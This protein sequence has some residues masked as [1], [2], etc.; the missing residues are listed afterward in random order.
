MNPT[1]FPGNISFNAQHSPMGAF[2]SFTCGHFGTRGGIG[3]Q[4]GRPAN[5]DLFVGVKNGDRYSDEPIHCLPFFEGA[6]D[7]GPKGLDEAAQAFLVEQGVARN[8]TKPGIVAIDRKDIHR[9]YRWATDAWHAH[10]FEFAIYTPFD[11]IPDPS[12]ESPA[13]ALLP[14]ITAELVVHN[15][16]SQTKTACFAIGFQDPG[17][18]LLD[19]GV[20]RGR[21][22]F[23]LRNQIGVLAALENDEAPHP[24]PFM[25]WSAHE[26]L[27]DHTPVHL[28]GNTPGIGFEIPPGESRSLRIA[29]GCYLDGVVT[30]RIE[31]KYFYTRHYA[32][33]TDVLRFALDR[34]TEFEDRAANL[35]LELLQS[36][37]SDDQQF[38][39][40]HSVR[41]YYGSTQL[42]DV[43][44]Q[45]FWIVNEGE[46]CMMN[47]LDLAVDQVFWELKQ[48]PWVVKNLLDNF[49]KSYS[50]HD[51]VKDPKTGELSPG[52][53]SFC[54]DMG[55]HNNFSPFGQ[56]SYELPNLNG[57][58]S[59]MTQEQLC[60]WILIAASYVAKTGDVEWLRSMEPIVR[61]CFYSLENRCR[62]GVMERDSARCKTGQE[63][64]TYDSLDESLGQARSNL[65]LAGK[66][67]AAFLG[68]HL[69][70]KQLNGYHGCIERAQAGS[71]TI[72]SAANQEGWMPAV[73]ETASNSRILPAIEGLLYPMYWKQ[74]SPENAPK[75]FAW[76]CL[77]PSGAGWPTD[78]DSQFP[79]FL[80]ALRKHTLTLLTDPDR[81]N[82]FPDG[83]L[84]LSSTSNNSWL[85]KIAIFQHVAREVFHLDD[86]PEIAQ[87][88]A[89]ADAA[90][91]K[92]ETDGSGYWAMCDQILSGKALGSK[93]YPRCVTTALWLEGRKARQTK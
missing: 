36:S 24:F 18:R 70:L 15:R 31:G 10:D 68:T 49:V 21:V 28:L 43:S 59:F 26:G 86:D 80:A 79:E 47:T 63:I 37:L 29:I 64:T 61:D 93:Y 54:H 81:R 60:N 73:F 69:L 23:A 3:V 72:V 74:E 16:S 35:D 40:A 1:P 19:E 71:S 52:G 20:G 22:G 62:N 8:S 41:S 17:V 91:V 82:L 55:V 50:Y 53:I 92:W 14:A 12:K 27:R 77:T 66:T 25:R 57:C 84:K 30:T 78:D 58:F 76:S 2:M 45:P 9:H 33:L 11:A 85:S 4:I 46:Y 7:G 44:G 39:I 51:Q 75:P 48:N 34:F 32:N 42:L 6:L 83:G 89:K 5:Q 87:L 65:Y 67:W 90:H 13:D 56:S 38:L 88:F